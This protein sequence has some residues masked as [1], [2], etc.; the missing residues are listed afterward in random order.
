MEDMIEGFNGQVQELDGKEK[1]VLTL[2][3][4]MEDIMAEF[5]ETARSAN[6][7]MNNRINRPLPD[8]ARNDLPN[9]LTP[10]PDSNPDSN[11]APNPAPT[12]VPNPV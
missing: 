12:P 9:D 4:I 8:V 6:E 5:N 11:P 1:K 2:Y 7:E 10:N 3:R